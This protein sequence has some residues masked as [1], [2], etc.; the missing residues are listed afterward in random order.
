MRSGSPAACPGAWE[1][2]VG[3]GVLV[4]RAPWVPCS[5]APAAASFL[6]EPVNV[7]ACPRGDL[8]AGQGMHRGDHMAGRDSEQATA[9]ARDRLT[10]RPAPCPVRP[11]VPV[12]LAA[13]VLRGQ[14]LQLLHAPLQVARHR[15]AQRLGHR[16]RGTRVG[17][18][19]AAGSPL[20]YRHVG[21]WRSTLTQPGAGGTGGACENRGGRTGVT[22]AHEC[23]KQ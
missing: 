13:G 6:T 3:C 2:L 18:G 19:A 20:P 1:R 7:T 17:S 4:A 9:R 21:R 14:R 22:P 16:R 8:L 10:L 11:S 5:Q 12:S 23:N 15:H